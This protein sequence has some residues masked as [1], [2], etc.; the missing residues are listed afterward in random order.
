MVWHVLMAAIA[1]GEWN[2]ITSDVRGSLMKYLICLLLVGCA[3]NAMRSDISAA[4]QLNTA[5]LT[6]AVSLAQSGAISSKQLSEVYGVTNAVE[7]ALVLGEQAENVGNT[8]G[9][10]SIYA[11]VLTTVGAVTACLTPKAPASTIDACIAGV[12]KP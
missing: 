11:A 1:H 4:T 12:P 10:Q 5:S 8:T 3:S 6:L 2:S 7:A 9:A